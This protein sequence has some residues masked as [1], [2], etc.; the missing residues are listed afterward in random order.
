ML[1]LVL[2][3]RHGAVSAEL[4][5][6]IRRLNDNQL[7]QLVTIAATAPSLDEVITAVDDLLPQTQQGNGGQR[8]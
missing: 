1:L 4:A 6:R 5:T 8:P 7:R 3:S 2:D